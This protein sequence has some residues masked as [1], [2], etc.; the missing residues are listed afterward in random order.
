MPNWC[1]GYVN[2]SGKAK[3]VEKFCSHFVFM[4]DEEKEGLKKKYFAR[5]FTQQSWESFKENHF[6]KKSN[7]EINIAFSVDF[8]WSCHSCMIE[9]YPQRSPKDNI[10]LEW[11]CKKYDVKVH[12][13]TEEIGCCFEEEITADKNGVIDTCKDMPN[14]TCSN[15][16]KEQAMPTDCEL[17]E[18][19]CYNC[20]TT[21]EW[22]DK[23]RDMLKKKVE[24]K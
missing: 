24:A 20:D 22:G 17:E 4:E 5:S 21:G 18:Q 3:N 8:A 15:C 1:N 19:T 11:A 7:K 6:K 16:G 12:I 13:T 23:L 9:G 2:V 10:T 14:Y